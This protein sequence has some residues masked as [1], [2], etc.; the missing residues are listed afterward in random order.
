MLQVCYVVVGTGWDRHA[1]M[2]WISAHSVRQQHKTARIIVVV[3]GA[4]PEATAILKTRFSQIADSVL[5]RTAEAPT[6]VDKNRLHRMSLRDYIVGDF[7]YLDSDTLAVRSF[8]DVL[9]IRA[10]VG[11]V[12]DFNFDLQRRFFPPNFKQPFLERGWTYPLPYYLNSGVV[13]MRDTSAVHAFCREWIGRWRGSS[14]LPHVW[15]QATFNSALFATGVPHAVLH[16]GY[17]AMVVKRNYRFATSRILHFFGSEDEQR[18]TILEHLLSRLR[19]TGVFDEAAYRTC[20]RQQHPWGPA[21][22][23]WHLWHSRNYMRA[24]TLKLRRT[25]RCVADRG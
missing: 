15:D 11:A 4:T 13:L 3:E 22:E 7:L 1:Q 21:H 14:A 17:N 19:E 10:D 12:T 25:A 8:G 6:L 16:H 23:P 9:D 20:L 24:V 2:A 18:G 5:P